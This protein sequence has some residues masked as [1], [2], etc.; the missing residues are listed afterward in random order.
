MARPRKQPAQK[1][2]KQSSRH[3]RS[4]CAWHSG[5]T[6]GWPLAASRAPRPSR[7]AK[8][9]PDIYVEKQDN[10]TVAEIPGAP[11]RSLLP[12]LPGYDLANGFGM[13]ECEAGTTTGV[14]GGGKAGL[15][16]AQATGHIPLLCCGSAGE[17]LALEGQVDRPGGASSRPHFSHLLSFCNP[18]PY[19]LWVTR[20][21][22]GVTSSKWCCLAEPG[23]GPKWC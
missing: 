2:W 4:Y 7:G 21:E 6:S 12:G 5:H 9:A 15:I 11:V 8:I 19:V 3:G 14:E 13:L 18:P 16:G 23:R 1:L 17:W 20:G 22:V 10:R